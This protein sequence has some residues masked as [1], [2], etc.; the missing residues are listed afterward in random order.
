MNGFVLKRTD[1]QFV[2]PPGSQRSYTNSLQ[3]ARIFPTREAAQQDACGN[4]TVVPL[5]QLLHT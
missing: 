3:S 2:T 5:D 1:G 4:E